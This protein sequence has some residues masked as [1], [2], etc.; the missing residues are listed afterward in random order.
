MTAASGTRTSLAC[1]QARACSLFLSGTTCSR[2]HNRHKRAASR[3]K[4]GA[5]VAHPLTIHRRDQEPGQVSD[6]FPLAVRLTVA[7]LTLAADEALPQACESLTEQ[8]A[9]GPFDAC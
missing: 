5:V 3:A 4:A 6:T 1:K 9:G 8:A 7:T 2:T